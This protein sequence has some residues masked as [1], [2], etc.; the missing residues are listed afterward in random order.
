MSARRS[1]CRDR[2]DPQRRRPYA[3]RPE[4][5]AIDSER[6]NTKKFTRH[7]AVLAAAACLGA[8]GSKQVVSAAQPT[9]VTNNV[10]QTHLPRAHKRYQRLPGIEH[11]SGSVTTMITTLPD[12]S[13]KAHD[14]VVKISVTFHATDPAH[15]GTV[16]T[17]PAGPVIEI[18][19]PGSSV[20]TMGIG[21]DGHVTML[22]RRHVWAEIGLT[23]RPERAQPVGVG[24]DVQGRPG[25][26][27]VPAGRHVRRHR[28]TPDGVTDRHCRSRG[29]R[30][31]KGQRKCT[32]KRCGGSSP[33]RSWG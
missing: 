25:A 8:R 22:G 16:T 10:D 7:M 5:S 30:K 1:R 29:G 15:T 23:V 28:G 18:D 20:T 27:C 31:Q 3:P 19:D 14:V 32:S 12:R 24:P 4:P 11:D 21:Q 6:T 2:T 33:P 13:V 17:R 9:I 26:R